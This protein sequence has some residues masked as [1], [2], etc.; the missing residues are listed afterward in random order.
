[1]PEIDSLPSALAY[2]LPIILWG[3]FTGVLNLAFTYKSQ[4]EAWV[5][6][7]PRLA[8]W[9]K[10]LRSVGFDPWA[11]RAWLL[12]LIKKRLPDAQQANSAVAKNEQRK[13]DAK[14]LGPPSGGGVALPFDIDEKTP[15][16]LPG[17]R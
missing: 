15:P 3:A 2:L 6:A 12:L 10:F 16:S 11:F 13:A 4:I 14:R 5:V 7:N 9:A 8:A 17:T 1:M